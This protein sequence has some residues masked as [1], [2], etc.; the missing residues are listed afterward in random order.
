M[1]HLEKHTMTQTKS[2]DKHCNNKDTRDR[3]DHIDHDKTKDNYNLMRR[4]LEP[5]EYFEQRMGELYHLDREDLKVTADWVVTLPEGWKGDEKE[6]F[7]ETCDYL[8]TLYGSENCVFATV[9]LDEH[10]PH[11]HYTFIPVA[12]DLNP[13]HTQEE[14][15]CAKEVL[16]KEHLREFHPKLQEHLRERIPDRE[17]KEIKVHGIEKERVKD[18]SLEQYKTFQEQ[19]RL[20]KFKEQVHKKEINIQSKEKDLQERND[21]VEGY[22]TYFKEVDRY[23]LEHGLTESQYQRELYM[24]RLNPDKSLPEPEHLNPDRSREE[25]EDIVREYQLINRE[26]KEQEREQDREEPE[27]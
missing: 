23:C 13:S 5:K 11:M 19:S 20:A 4:D 9:H 6:F 1:A 3:Q 14:K 25:R 22:N 27:R 8:N 10:Q 2:I 24:Q 7:V 16:T 15:V 17:E 18:R 12:R 21:R 26:N